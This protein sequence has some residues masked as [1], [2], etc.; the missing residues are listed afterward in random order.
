LKQRGD[1]APSNSNHSRDGTLCH[2]R[3]L[4][5]VVEADGGQNCESAGQ[6][7]DAGANAIVAGSAIFGSPVYGA[8]IAAI[9]MAHR[10]S[11]RKARS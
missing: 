11:A 9:R 1:Y 4:S 6:A 5:P 10:P 2:A 7:I 3:G 8:A